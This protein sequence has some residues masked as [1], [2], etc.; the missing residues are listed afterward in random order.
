VLTEADLG[1]LESYCVSAG[2]IRECQ[3]VINRDGVM[4]GNKRHPAFGM[5]NSSQATMRLAAN[6]LGLTPVSRSRPSIRD[7]DPGDDDNPLDIV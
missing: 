2:V 5:M 3:R 7:D 6:E 1:T 4:L